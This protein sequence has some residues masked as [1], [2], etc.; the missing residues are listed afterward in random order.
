MARALRPGGRLAVSVFHA[1]FVVRN[2]EAGET[3][4]P[5][6]GVL[7]ELATVRGPDGDE[8]EFDLWTTCVSGRRLA[9][10]AR[11]AGLAVDA[12]HGVTPGRYRAVPPHLDAPELLLLARDPRR[13]ATGRNANM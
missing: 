1:P 2:L 5:A 11:G 8:R 6:T 4:D 13:A 12:V 7:H 3:F 9:E 10:L